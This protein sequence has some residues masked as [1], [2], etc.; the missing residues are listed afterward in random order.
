M[1][2][3]TY[4][5]LNTFISIVTEILCHH[6]KKVTMKLLRFAGKNTG[7]LLLCLMFTLQSTY[8]QSQKKFL[9]SKVRFGELQSEDF[10]QKMP[11]SDSLPHAAVL[12]DIG[13]TQFE[14]NN[15]SWFSIVFNRHKRIQILEKNGFSHAT[16]SIPLYL[17]DAT[18]EEEKFLEFEALTHNMVNGKIETTKLEKTSV[19]RE[20]RGKNWMDVKFT[21]PN[22]KEGSIVEYQYK[23]VSPYF[24]NLQPW[25]FQS[26][27]PHL[28]SEY[29]VSVPVDIFDYSLLTQ[30]YLP[31]ALDTVA[32]TRG[33]YTVRQDNGTR[34]SDNY[35]V[36]SKIMN[37][38][39]A[40]KEVPALKTENFIT[41]L[42]NYRQKVQFQLNKIKYSQT[43]VENYIGNFTQ[44]ADK[45]MKSEHFGESLTQNNGWLADGLAGVTKGAPDKLSAAQMIYAYF[46]DNFVCKNKQGLYLSQSLRKVF[47]EKSGTV[48]EINLLMTA[49]LLKLGY[50]A[51]PL[52]ISTRENGKS[53]EIYPMLD[54]YNY[55]AVLL[56]INNQQFT[57]DATSP[58]LAF[59]KLPSR[60]YNGSGRIIDKKAPLLVSL[61]PDSLVERKTVTIFLTN[62]EKKV[63]SGNFTSKPGYY[64]SLRFRENGGVGNEEEFARELK[65]KYAFDVRLSDIKADSVSEV[66]MPLTLKYKMSF[67]FNDEDIVYFNPMMAEASKSNPFTNANRFF[68]VELPYCFDDNYML[69]LDIPEGYQLDEAPG[70]LRIKMNENDGSFEYIVAKSDNKLMIRRRFRMNKTFFAPEDYTTLRDFFAKVVSKENEQF[71]FKKIKK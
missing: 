31:F 4:S 28:W 27:I 11:A 35:T 67:D 14:G 24:T 21:F 33:T 47:Q 9:Q 52:L 68:P 22:V 15:R 61:S 48:P 43:H 59:G 57:L 44:L 8:S 12:A 71:V 37:V 39:W 16:V 36:D 17:G 29:A 20:K 42:D 53:S 63:I 7:M 32:F 10:S 58:K 49:A 25:E 69:V 5:L 66:D 34:S 3:K 18:A 65:K 55:V 6:N 13:K 60:L 38:K 64:E 41:T 45:L 40:M 23:I 50:N 1:N 54:R 62:T 19:F 26:D 56:T 51:K 30:T 2:T 46:R 70:S